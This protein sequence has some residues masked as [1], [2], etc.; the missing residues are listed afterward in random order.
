MRRTRPGRRWRR[1]AKRSSAGRNPRRSSSRSSNGSHP[2]ATITSTMTE[3]RRSAVRSRISQEVSA[4][5]SGVAVRIVE[6]SLVGARI[7][8]EER[9]PLVG[10]HLSIR[11]QGMAVNVAL[12]VVRSEIAGRQESSLIYQTGVQ[13]I[14]IDS[15]A[16]RVIASILRDDTSG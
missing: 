6:L 16:Q 8:H 10:P 3:E 9:F 4:E 1:P 15:V 12:R 7:E 5:V 14:D 11:W 13:F 2:C